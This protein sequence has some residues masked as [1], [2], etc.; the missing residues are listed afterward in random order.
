MPNG[1]TTPCWYG[2]EVVAWPYTLRVFAAIDDDGYRVLPS[3]IARVGPAA[4]KLSD[5]L[6]SGKMSK[7]V[8]V[9]SDAPV[10]LTS[11]TRPP[12]MSMEVQRTSFDLPSRVAFQMYWLGRWTSRAEG[13]ARQ[14]RF[15][16]QRLSAERDSDTLRF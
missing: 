13:L 5:S 3:G 11:L 9:L 7:D 4:D 10:P 15:C 1:A 14:A 8:W 6:A 2:D 16:A 12:Q